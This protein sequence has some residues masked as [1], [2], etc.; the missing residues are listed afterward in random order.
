MIRATK[1]QQSQKILRR[2]WR[3]RNVRKPNFTLTPRATPS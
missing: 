2:F 3:L 1:R